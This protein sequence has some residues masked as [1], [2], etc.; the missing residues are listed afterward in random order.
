MK[1]DSTEKNWTRRDFLR[2]V[3]ASVP[4]LSLMMGAVDVQGSAEAGPGQEFDNSK[5]TPLNLTPY[6]NCSSLDLGPRPKARGLGGE[7]ARDGLIRTPAGD[8][9]LRGIPF[10][11]GPESSRDKRWLMLSA[12]PSLNSTRSV[13]IP[14]QQRANFLCMTSFCD[15]DKNQDAPPDIDVFEQ[16]GQRLGQIILVYEGGVEKSFPVRRRFEVNAPLGSW[17]HFCY[18]CV[19]WRDEAPR[20]LTDPLPNAEDW[21]RLQMAVTQ[22]SS[23]GPWICAL[24]SPDPERQLTAIRLEAS[25]EDPLFVCGLTLFHGNVS[26][27]RKERLSLYRFTLPEARAEDQDRWKVSVDLG[28]VA[29]TYALNDFD[30][31]A[32]LAS[33]QAGL[34]ERFDPIQGGRYLYAEVTASRAATLTLHDFSNRKRYEFELEEV[35][36]GRE[37]QAR[38]IGARVEIL[39]AGKTWLHGKV[40]DAGTGQPTPVRLAFRSQDGRY[41][42][43]YGHRTQINDAWFQDYGADLMLGDA[44]F[45]YV[46]GTF[47]VELPVGAVYLE[48]TKGYEYQAVRKKL[49]IRPGQRELNLE[50]PRLVDLRSKGWVSADTHVHFLPPA[51][52]VLEGQAEGLNLINILAAQLGD[53]FT[54]VGDLSHG[55]LNSKDGE[56]IVYV[57]TEN[58]QHLLGHIGLLGVHGNPVYPMSAS[59]PEESYLGDPLWS[60]LAEW[61]DQCR[62][63]EGLAV[64]V[65]FPYPTGEVAADIIMGKLDAVELWPAN[66]GFDSLRCLDWYRYLNCGYRLPVVGGT[67]KMGA[68]EAVG[69][70]RVYAYLGDA[71]F[72]FGSWAKAVRRGNTFMS[73][74]PLL[75][76]SVDGH[77]PGEEIRFRTGGGKLQV[78]AR[79][80][81]FFPIHR[82][83]V[84]F[85]GRVVASHEQPE[86]T[87]EMILK[88]E[89]KVP[90]PGW[91][92][93]RCQSRYCS[94]GTGQVPG[95][96]AHT[97]PIYVVVPGQEVFSPPAAAY[98]L[99]LIDG[100]QTWVE[101]LAIRPDSERYEK[102]RRL[103]V[104]ARAELHRRMHQ[105]GIAH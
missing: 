16:V 48:M 43:P 98:F 36:P 42:P 102:I 80:T 35:V 27:L 9:H 96:V 81:C 105:Q 67:D 24:P 100:A 22:N 20:E 47:Q 21:G 82:I 12:Q 56:T 40:V 93:A 85:N 51:T 68:N 54:N 92:A 17:G 8:Q 41:I 58:R 30:A 60:S 86:G 52:A 45:A 97:S 65:H 26:P 29:R 87:R 77:A 61:A 99:T 10:R 18:S 44:S 95:K 70:N 13:Q 38:P 3:G 90:G 69:A 11:L 49:D 73:T 25:S 14:V 19:A 76:F 74:G 53:L 4:T 39:E 32:W 89:V 59:G 62:E 37:L 79:A 72:N 94:L 64:G 71:E 1:E 66:Q 101:N 91:I 63:R 2:T 46:D 75:L 104:D 103:F 50:I 7:S 57:G 28:V 33:P 15:W 34:G 31:T 83:E 6:F 88:E 78:E 5:F 23:V 55:P 84:V